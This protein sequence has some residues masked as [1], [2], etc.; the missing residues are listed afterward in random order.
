M[1][2]SSNA[3]EL[4]VLDAAAASSGK[5]TVS[6]GK[7]KL[8]GAV[9]VVK[10]KEKDTVASGM[11]MIVSR[12]K[13]N[14]GKNI[15][16]DALI[17]TENDGKASKRRYLSETMTRRV[18]HL[19]STTTELTDENDHKI[20]TTTTMNDDN[21]ITLSDIARES[22]SKITAATKTNG[23]IINTTVSDGKIITTTT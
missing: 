22:K 21:L 20:F 23:K 17:T 16:T 2:S 6:T 4:V 15:S 3:V 8:K 7:N 13:L 11:V 9:E 18:Q 12:E 19:L 14:N 5:T 1:E 10:V